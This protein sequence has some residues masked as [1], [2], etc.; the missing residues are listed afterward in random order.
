M[1]RETR[2]RETVDKNVLSASLNKT[3][4][5]FSPTSKQRSVTLAQTNYIPYRYR[6][7][8]NIYIYIYIWAL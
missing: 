2:E 1:E 5:S 3:F 4:L 6:I 8:G 7:S